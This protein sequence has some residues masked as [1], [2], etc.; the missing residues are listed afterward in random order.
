MKVSIG[1]KVID[2][3]WGGGNLFVKNLTNFLRKNGHQVIY[4]LAESDIDLIL[5]TDPRSRK[6]SSSTFNHIDIDKYKKYVNSEV[7]VVQRINECDERKGTDNINKFYLEASN[8]ADKV[9]FVSTWLKN[10]YVDLGMEDKKTMVILAGADSKIFNPKN[11]SVWTHGDK[12]KIVTHHWSSHENKGFETYK[13]INDLTKSR[14]W[15]DKLEFSY[16]GNTNPD[17]KL[18]N[19]N[20]IQPLAG[21]DLANEIKTNHIY[22][23]ASIN[24]PSGN[25]HIEAAQCGL[26][27][28]FIDSGGVPE[29][30][31]NY[32]LSFNNNFEESLEFIMNNYDEF[33]KKLLEYPFNAQK[34]CEEFYHLFKDLLDS[35][36]PLV[37]NHYQIVGKLFILKNK[38]SKLF[39]DTIFSNLK[40]KIRTLIKVRLKKWI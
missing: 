2:G 12:V 24:E 35:G 30:C 32:G 39:R 8:S 34:M 16:I 10:I 31:E 13:L 28:L 5:L 14:K 4:D 38:F 25:H 7:K 33:E 21:E 1:S 37:N 23:T 11:K 6:E 9:V 36:Q 17:Y 29:Y 20:L 22:V 27:I 3:P 18:G 19:T 15:K 40:A 26:P